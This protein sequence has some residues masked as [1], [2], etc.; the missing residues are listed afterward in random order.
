MKQIFICLFIYLLKYAICTINLT[1]ARPRLQ[2][3][4]YALNEEPVKMGL[5]FASYT[6]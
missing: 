3:S 2:E 1:K 4:Y 5:K 6:L